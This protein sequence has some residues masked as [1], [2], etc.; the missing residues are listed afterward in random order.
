MTQP[1]ENNFQKSND[2]FY[3]LE[4]ARKTCIDFATNTVT[5]QNI[6]N[7]DEICVEE[8]IV[9]EDDRRKENCNANELRL[10]NKSWL[11]LNE[12]KKPL[13]TSRYSLN[14]NE[15]VLACDDVNT[16]K[17][18]DDDVI[19]V[20]TYTATTTTTMTAA[21]SDLRATSSTTASTVSSP[22]PPK[23]RRKRKNKTPVIPRRNPR[24]VAQMEKASVQLAMKLSI[25]K[26]IFGCR[27]KSSTEVV[28]S[29]L[30]LSIF[31]ESPRN[32][33]VLYTRKKTRCVNVTRIF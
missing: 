32:L 17:S 19:F 24:R 6:E 26:R 5:I 12:Q 27:T 4:D 7:S 9:I 13:D 25:S 20:T 28:V 21:L 15:V 14:D 22:S 1:S 30:H 10:E 8:T 23:L 31:I 18:S 16:T 2:G 3:P 33:C 11:P 29:C